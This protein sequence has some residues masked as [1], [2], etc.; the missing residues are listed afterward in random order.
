[1]YPLEAL[2][3]DNAL[4]TISGEVA[5]ADGNARAVSWPSFSQATESAGFAPSV[6]HDQTSAT[7]RFITGRATA[8][9]DEGWRKRG[10]DLPLGAVERPLD[11]PSLLP[12]PLI[13]PGVTAVLLK[14]FQ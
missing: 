14:C 9:P 2:T 11:L 13:E 4:R 12:D 5:Q 3:G 6:N 7:S 8:R 1:M 10:P